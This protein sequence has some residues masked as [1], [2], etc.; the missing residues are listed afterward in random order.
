[1][2]IPRY[3]VHVLLESEKWLRFRVTGIFITM[4]NHVQTKILK[5]LIPM[6]MLLLLNNLGYPMPV[7]RNDK[8]KT[9]GKLQSPSLKHQSMTLHHQTMPG[10]AYFQEGSRF[11]LLI[12]KRCKQRKN[13]GA[14]RFEHMTSSN[15]WFYLPVDYML[16]INL[17]TF[18][19]A[20][21][22]IIMSQ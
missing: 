1:M 22:C 19:T 18:D 6:Q 5:T 15:T 21:Y 14:W 3:T 4:I 20:S 16:I 12:T 17:N 10:P 7:R 9:A 8:S 2:I 13:K 11:C